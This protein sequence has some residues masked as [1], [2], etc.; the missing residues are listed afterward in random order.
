MSSSGGDHWRRIDTISLPAPLQSTC[1]ASYPTFVGGLD[2]KCLVVKLAPVMQQ[3]SRKRHSFPTT[4][5]Y[6]SDA[7]SL[8][9]EIDE[10]QTT[11]L[12]WRADAQQ[13]IRS[14][15][16]ASER[17][18]NPGGFTHIQVLCHAS[19]WQHL[20]TEAW[21]YLEQCGFH[22]M[23]AKAAYAIL[24]FPAQR[25]AQERT[26]DTVRYMLPPALYD[27]QS[28]PNSRNKKQIWRLA[29][30]IQY[31]R[32]NF[33]LS[34]LYGVVGTD[35]EQIAQQIVHNISPAMTKC[36]PTEEECSHLLDP[37]FCTAHAAAIVSY[38]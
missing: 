36:S 5:L 2:I 9:Y 6:D 28:R 3:H 38:A 12:E 26:Q 15:A 13:I 34:N 30:Q 1:S 27:D 8:R 18:Q 29:K 31:Q 7:T 16:I 25:E 32:Q 22:P 17:E 35:P 33:S 4:F 37:F 10:L 20:P 24:V 19:D 11:R 23:T 21:S 14:L